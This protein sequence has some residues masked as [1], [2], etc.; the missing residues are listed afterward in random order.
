M[1]FHFYAALSP[2]LILAICV[3]TSQSKAFR[4]S[5]INTNINTN[6]NSN[7]YREFLSSQLNSML[8][9]GKKG[10]AVAGMASNASIYRISQP[11]RKVNKLQ[12]CR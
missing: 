6:V 3:V 7:F 5:R 4:K 10:Q 8:N 2:Y 9:Q 1:R 11:S 12:K